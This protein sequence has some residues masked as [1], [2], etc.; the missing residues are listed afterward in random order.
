MV[1]TAALSATSGANPWASYSFWQGKE[2]SKAR[3][4]EAVM[5]VHVEGQVKVD[6]CGSILLY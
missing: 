2:K 6:I 1:F 3:D 4:G 5:L